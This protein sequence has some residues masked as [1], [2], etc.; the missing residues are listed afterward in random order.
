MIFILQNV[1]LLKYRGIKQKSNFMNGSKVQIKSD[2]VVLFF[3][4]DNWMTFLTKKCKAIFYY[5][6]LINFWWKKKIL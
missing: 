2:T 1:Y 3:W 4:L 6:K 5:L